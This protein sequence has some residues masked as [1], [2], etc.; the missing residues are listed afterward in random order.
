MEEIV[1]TTVGELMEFGAV[2]ETEGALKV[3]DCIGDFVTDH[4]D[5]FSVYTDSVPARGAVSMLDAVKDL[6][7]ALSEYY[8]K[9]DQYEQILAAAMVRKQ[10]AA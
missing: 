4:I 9:P 8:K 3:L 10:S 2:R 7:A 1:E 6:L 5:R